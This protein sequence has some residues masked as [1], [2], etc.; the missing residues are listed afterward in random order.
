M[1]F[2]ISSC[3]PSPLFSVLAYSAI[4]KGLPPR[5]DTY[6]LSNSQALPLHLSLVAGV[7][8]WALNA[9]VA[10]FFAV[11]TQVRQHEWIY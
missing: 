3:I 10:L 4:L 1:I 5:L 9:L 8:G 7:V 6:P 2:G 11:V